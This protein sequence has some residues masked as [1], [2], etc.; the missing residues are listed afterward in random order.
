MITETLV[1]GCFRLLFSAK[2]GPLDMSVYQDLL[3][4]FNYSSKYFYKDDVAVAVLS[5]LDFIKTTC[6]QMLKGGTIV[7]VITAA[8]VSQKYKQH[9]DLIT[10]SQESSMGES[11]LVKWQNALQKWIAFCKINSTFQRFDKY[12]EIVMD[13]NF[14]TIEDLIEEF[15][16]MV[17]TASSDVADYELGTRS[18]LVSSFNTRTDEYDSVLKEIG[19][20]Y[21]KTNVVPSGIPELDNE[22]LN[23]GFQPSRVHF[24]AGT[25]GIGK[26]LLLINFAIRGAMT[27][28]VSSLFG[29]P[30]SSF[31]D[32]SPER[33]FLYVTMENY[34]YETWL[35]LY[36]SLFKRTKNEML[37]E[38]YHQKITADSI[39]EQ[40]NEKMAPYNSS[41]QIEYF[42]ANTIS[43]ATI[44]SLI[45]KLNQHPDKASVKA[46]YIDYLDLM[47]PDE[48]REFYRLDLGEITS[49]FKSIAANFEIPIITAT[50]LNREAYRKGKGAEPGS[51]MISESMQKLFIADFSAMMYLDD[52]EEITSDE[53]TYVPRKVVLKVDKNRDGKTGKTHIYINYPESRFLTQQECVEEYS[54]LLEI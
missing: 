13:G 44:S 54:K 22:F 5:K 17:K 15:S 52:K 48:R 33:V 43:P 28:A 35:R 42:P 34:V 51:E 25:S 9:M 12:R 46:V 29:F 26:S 7:E 24:I 8:A 10:L 11:E 4:F 1:T 19:K 20:K 38:L 30:E 18:E 23:G 45:G 49:R 2:P 3:L 39:K 36:C 21:S 6:K 47:I 41:I 27:N 50:Q 40:I 32:S 53:G 14:D 31:L 37:Q 16:D